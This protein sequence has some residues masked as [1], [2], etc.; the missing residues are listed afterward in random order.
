MKLSFLGALALTAALCF[1]APL[2][3]STPIDLNTASAEQIAAALSGI[4]PAKAQAI[5]DY[6]TE[7]GS[8]VSVEELTQVQGIGPATLERNRDLLQVEQVAVQDD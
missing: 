5:V 4:G 2:S 7:K 1:T 3:A 8:F 6:R